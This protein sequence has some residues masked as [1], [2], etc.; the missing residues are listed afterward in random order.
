MWHEASIVID[1]ST[2]ASPVIFMRAIAGGGPLGNIAID[3]VTI[4]SCMSSLDALG[5]SGIQNG[6]M[7]KVFLLFKRP[8]ARLLTGRGEVLRSEISDWEGEVPIG[9]FGFCALSNMT[10][11]LRTEHYENDNFLLMQCIHMFI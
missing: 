5:G 1:G 10:G 2:P 9:S 3:D 4:H 6:E 8:V 11:I 7:K